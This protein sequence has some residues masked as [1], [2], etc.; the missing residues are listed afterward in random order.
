[1]T[2]YNLVSYFGYS[3]ATGHFLSGV[4]TSIAVGSPRDNTFRGKVKSRK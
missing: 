2:M 3:L 1:M 4:D